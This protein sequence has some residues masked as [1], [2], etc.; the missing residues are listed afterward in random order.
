MSGFGTISVTSSTKEA[1]S[2]PPVRD[3][4]PGGSPHVGSSTRSPVRPRAAIYVLRS[5]AGSAARASDPAH[6]PPSGIDGVGSPGRCQGIRSPLA[7]RHEPTHEDLRHSADHLRR[8][9]AAQAGR[10]RRVRRPRRRITLIVGV[11]W[12]FGMSPSCS[13]R[14]GRHRCCCPG[15]AG[16]GPRARRHRGGARRLDALDVVQRRRGRAYTADGWFARRSRSCWPRCSSAGSA[17][18]RSGTPAAPPD[19]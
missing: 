14:R 9:L 15:R 16:L 19:R 1:S 11:L 5:E 3:R 2:Q 18:A 8:L 4:P 12:A 17:S 10:H 6:P 7:S 13:P